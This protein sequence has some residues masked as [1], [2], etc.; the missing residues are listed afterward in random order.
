MLIR[1][2]SVTKTYAMGVQTISAL[3]DV[4]LNIEEGAFIAIAGPSGPL[5][6][7]W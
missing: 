2:E 7:R 4:S 3:R 1:L 6:R 5:R